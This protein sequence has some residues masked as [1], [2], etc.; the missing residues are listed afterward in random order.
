MRYLFIYLFI[1]LALSEA[2]AQK[3]NYLVYDPSLHSLRVKP[4]MITL[5]LKKD[6]GAV[7]NGREN[8]KENSTTTSDHLAFEAAADFINARGGY[9]RLLI[10]YGTYVV[11][12]QVFNGGRINH[13]KK[14]GWGEYASFDG[15]EVLLLLKAKN[16]SIEGVLSKSGLKPKLQYKAG[17][18]FGLFEIAKGQANVTKAEAGTT[19]LYLDKTGLQ[20]AHIGN[21]FAFMAC[22]DIVLRNIE[23][24]GNA[25]S[26]MLGGKFGRGKNPYENYHTGICISSCSSV[27]LLDITLYDLGLDGIA[28]KDMGNGYS[29]SD[30]ILIKNCLVTRNGRNGL[31]WLSGRNVKVIDSEF[32][33]MGRGSVSTEPAAG[34]DIESETVDPENVPVLGSFNNCIIKNNQWLAL[35]AGVASLNGKSMPSKKI[36]FMNCVFV[37]TYN[38]VA[39]IESDE[40]AF[41]SCYF[42]GQ[43][44]LRNNSAREKDATAFTNCNFSNVYKGKRMTGMFLVA[45]VGARRTR[46]KKCSFLGFDQR[47]FDM[48]NTTFVCGDYKSYPVYEDCIFRCYLTEITDGWFKTS[49]L[50][51]KT[52]Y[53]GNTFYYNALYPFFNDTYC[54]NMG[55]QDLGGNKYIPLKKEEIIAA[56]KK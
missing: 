23:V 4:G 53:K 24:N 43:L 56:L 26:F 20:R 11:G 50:G 18:R 12:K 40:Y 41:D 22:S 19:N 15:F 37:G 34:I 36:N 7:G 8:S 14:Y 35:A 6:F 46:F 27:Q 49:G 31:S 38:S 44:Y 2:S 17:M 54:G 16:V 13:F 32:S 33:E 5:D 48:D 9:V 10:P 30:N 3:T 47:I 1:I 51:G 29:S 55:A 21:T 45:N 28:I 42:Y 39:D 52:S 25:A